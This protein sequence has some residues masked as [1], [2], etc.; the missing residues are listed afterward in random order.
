MKKTILCLVMP[1][2]LIS[3]SANGNSESK[4]TFENWNECSALTTLKDFVSASVDKNSKDYIEKK[5]RLAVFDMD[6]TLY[7]ELFPS[8]FEYSMYQYRVLEDPTYKDKADEDQIL[9]ANEIKAGKM[10]DSSGNEVNTAGNSFPSGTDMRHAKLAAKAYSNM[11][12]KEFDDYCKAFLKKDVPMFTGMTYAE[13][14]YQPMKEVVSYLQENEYNVYVVSGSDRFICRALCCDYLN[15]APDH[16]IGMD[17]VLKATNQG[18][19][20]GV[21]YTFQPT[22]DVYRT[23]ELIIKT[24]KFN[25]VAQI[26]QEIGQQPVLSFGNSGGDQAMHTYTITDNPHP[27]AAFMLVADDADRDYAVLE[28]TKD[29]PTK[30]SN[31]GFNV[32]S[33]KNDFKTIYPK[34]VVKAS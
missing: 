10:T 9:L 28:K 27:S 5:D 33:M 12:L 22:D 4:T 6:G 30:W 16:I 29:L 34:N 7:G 32:V 19:T 26:C 14:F 25:K 2:L 15:I 21:G 31:L 8:Y 24:L 3:C 17:V 13:A 23:E 11:T 1:L 18:D 20:A